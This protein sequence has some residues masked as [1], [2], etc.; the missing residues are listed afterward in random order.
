[1]TS[2]RADEEPGLRLR[3]G[4]T[5][6]SYLELMR[7]PNV[8][9][10]MADVAM[11]FL[12]IQPIDWRWDPGGTRGRWACCWP[13]RACSTSPASC[14]TTCSTWKSTAGSG[15]SGRCRRA[16]SRSAA[17]AGWNCGWRLL[18]RRRPVGGRGRPAS[19]RATSRPGV[20]AALLAACILLYDAWLKRTPLGPLA[21]GGCRM[22]NV[23][24]GMSALGVPL[25]AEHGSWPAASAFTWPA[26]RGSPVANR[27]PSSRLPTCRWPRW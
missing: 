22:L 9:T 3:N 11:G 14:S 23:L 16:G 17:A 5:V 27:Q 12:F 8:F 18:V 26:S 25:P 4:S 7:L 1:M 10:A 2:I 19:L 6:R 20:V 21:M 13:R 24:L 15:P